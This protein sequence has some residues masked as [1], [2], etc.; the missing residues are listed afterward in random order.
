MTETHITVYQ[1]ASDIDEKQWARLVENHDVRLD[2]RWFLLNENDIS[3][4]SRYIAL[5]SQKGDLDALAPCLLSKTPG[6]GFA[7]YRATD[8]LFSPE[9]IRGAD[10][11]GLSRT[12]LIEAGKYLRNHLLFPSVAV[13]SPYSPY[14]P[15]SELFNK[16]I[17][18]PYSFHQFISSIEELARVESAELWAILGIPEGSPL[19]EQAGDYGFLPAI[20]SADTAMHVPWKTFNDYL[21]ALP[22]RQRSSARRELARLSTHAITIALEPAASELI[23]DLA[24]ISVSHHTAHGHSVD[25]E[26]EQMYFNDIVK[27]FGKDFQVIGARR[28]GELIGFCSL[29]SNGSNHKGFEYG[30]DHTKADRNDDLFPNLMYGVIR[31]II[32]MGGGSFTFSPT[33][34]KAKLLR[35]CSIK[36]LWGLYKPLNPALHAAL[37]EYLPHFNR[38][39]FAAFEALKIF[40]GHLRS[41]GDH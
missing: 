8:A 4:E 40:Q 37:L 33:N 25:L 24:R 31:R 29:L 14:A 30:V 22:S 36:L 5:W 20:V 2:R 32:E 19:L 1:H 23:H 27:L 16:C 10:P 15:I 26:S 38:L 28:H 6:T 21:T 11:V 41:N 13:A 18:N 7:S 3:A 35:G 17:A 9:I 34:Y 12:D 39:Q